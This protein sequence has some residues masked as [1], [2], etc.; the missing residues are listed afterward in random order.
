M[1]FSHRY[2]RGSDGGEHIDEAAVHG[3]IA[4]RAALRNAGDFNGADAIRDEL[5]QVHSVVL[6]DKDRVYM[7][8]T[9]T[10]PAR[11]PKQQRT[12]GAWK[13]PEFQ[14]T[15]IFVQG[16]SLAVSW[17]QLKD[18][19]QDAGLP[20]VYASVSFDR[21]TQ[22]SKGCGIVQFETVEATKQ[23]IARMD[24]S[25]LNGQPIHCR[26]DVQDHR[27][28]TPQ[29]DAVADETSRY[30]TGLKLSKGTEQTERRRKFRA[31]RSERAEDLSSLLLHD[32]SKQR[33]G[34]R[35]VN[36][37]G[38]DYARTLQDVRVL[39]PAIL[40]E[41]NT[42]LARRL[43]AKLARDF[44]TSDRCLRQLES[45]FGVHVND[46]TRQW[47]ADGL[48]FERLWKKIDAEG[49]GEWVDED[50]ILALIAERAERRKARD[51]DSADE[52]LNELYTDHGVVISD[53]TFT[54]RVLPRP[55]ELHG[56]GA[57][58]DYVRKEDDTIALSSK[59]LA[60]IDR[61][62]GARLAAKKARQF[63]EA[64]LVQARLRRLGVEVDDRGLTKDEQPT[65]RVKYE[66]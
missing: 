14:A 59:K 34:E 31:V 19:F 39:Q 50:E 11:S 47:R 32:S 21:R 13:G 24:G 6:W 63:A 65:W 60:Q 10:P 26:Q 48:S 30:S 64:D 28:S 42:I 23:A 52:I 40:A 66:K 36:S 25:I 58:H 37:Y 1:H 57:L 38:H 22:R 15:R 41:I 17:Q 54:W 49:D 33:R 20:T 12:H 53:K 45:E 29:T 61:L 43:R 2:T 62:L 7:V 18:H 8:G 9:D 35:V 3:L 4:A 46:E 56:G 55:S 51:F 44:E 5:Q 16:L 27:L